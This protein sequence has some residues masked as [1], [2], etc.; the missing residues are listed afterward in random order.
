MAETEISADTDTEISAETDTETDNFRSL[1]LSNNTSLSLSL[2]TMIFFPSKTRPSRRWTN[3]LLNCQNNSSRTYPLVKRISNYFWPTIHK[4]KRVHFLI[5]DFLLQKVT[6][7][8]FSISRSNMLARLTSNLASGLESSTT[9]RWG[10]TTERCRARSTSSVPTSTAHS[11]RS[12]VSKSA[13]TRK[14][15]SI[16]RMMK[17]EEQKKA[18]LVIFSYFLSLE[19]TF[20][21]F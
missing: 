11:S 13:I 3:S 12:P 14:R 10:S 8:Y 4:Y 2:I 6:K 9:S 21:F 1:I 15:K 16:F 7:L 19:S 18:L 5:L 20:I 17:C